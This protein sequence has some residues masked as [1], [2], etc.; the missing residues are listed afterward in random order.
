MPSPPSPLPFLSPLLS[1][2]LQDS[3]PLPFPSPFTSLF[4]LLPSPF[5]RPISFALP[6]FLLLFVSFP[7]TSLTTSTTLTSTPYPSPPSL[8]LSLSFPSPLPPLLLPRL[9]SRDSAGGRAGGDYVPVPESALRML[10]QVA[11]IAGSPW[12][13]SYKRDGNP[14]EE[15]W[16]ASLCVA[17]TWSGSLWD[18][19]FLI[20]LS[21]KWPTFH[22]SFFKGLIRVY[23]LSVYLLFL[24][25]FFWPTGYLFVCGTCVGYACTGIDLARV[26]ASYIYARMH[27]NKILLLCMCTIKIHRVSQALHMH[28]T[29]WCENIYYTDLLK[30]TRLDYETPSF[31]FQIT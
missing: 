11:L 27:S 29:G 19:F 3:I 4:P 12:L 6:P 14:K 7:L 1:L 28:D 17:G 25:F 20:I 30:P 18:L 13:N 16:M 8:L 26:C 24:A 23:V 2:P 5:L 31:F 22:T 21:Q 10:S 9:W 15:A